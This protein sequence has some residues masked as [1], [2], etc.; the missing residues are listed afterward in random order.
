MV[1]DYRE[2]RPS[3]DLRRAQVKVCHLWR[4]DIFV[5]NANNLILFLHSNSNNVTPSTGYTTPPGSCSNNGWVSLPH[6]YSP[7]S[8]RHGRL[9]IFLPSRKRYLMDLKR[10]IL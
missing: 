5:L 7:W 6:N 8:W 1:Y 9:S 4:S 10:A 2:M 3:T